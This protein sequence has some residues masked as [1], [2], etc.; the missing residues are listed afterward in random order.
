MPS[1]KSMIIGYSP[2]IEVH[3]IVI[4]T[5]PLFPFSSAKPVIA[6]SLAVATSILPRCPLRPHRVQQLPTKPSAGSRDRRQGRFQKPSRE[7]SFLGILAANGVFL[8]FGSSNL[9]LGLSGYDL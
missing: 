1:E 8:V 7:S 6:T 3:L 5:Y 4:R 9:E 2:N